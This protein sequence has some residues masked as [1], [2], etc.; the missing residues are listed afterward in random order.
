MKLLLKETERDKADKQQRDI[1]GSRHCMPAC[2]H[3]KRERNKDGVM[4]CRQ[5]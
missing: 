5:E 1:R 2:T 4:S 3:R